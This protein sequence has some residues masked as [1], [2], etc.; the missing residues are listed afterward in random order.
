MIHLYSQILNYQISFALQYSR[1]AFFRVLRDLVCANSWKG[2]C[3]DLGEIEKSIERAR[4]HLD[5]GTLNEIRS[6]LSELQE[7]TYR[8]FNLLKDTQSSVQVRQ[9]LSN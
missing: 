1:P 3:A 8:S 9:A 7:T 4:A 2:M 6:E 5:T